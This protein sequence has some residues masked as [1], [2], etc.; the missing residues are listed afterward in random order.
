MSISHNRS[1]FDGKSDN[2]EPVLDNEIKEEFYKI[3]STLLKDNSKYE[4]IYTYEA[5]YDYLKKYDKLNVVYYA[6]I[7]TLIYF[8]TDQNKYVKDLSSNIEKCALSVS[9]IYQACK[10]DEHNWVIARIYRFIIKLGDHISLAESQI[11][12]IVNTVMNDAVAKINELSDKMNDLV[13]TRSTELLNNMDKKVNQRFS[14]NQKRMK[15]FYKGLEK[16]SITILGIFVAIIL[17]FMGSIILPS[18]LIKNVSN[19]SIARLVLVFTG[20]AFIFINMLYLLIKFIVI[21]NDKDKYLNKLSYI[22]G[23]N[24]CLLIIFLISLLGVFF[25]DNIVELQQS[26]LDN[27]SKYL[28]NKTK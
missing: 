28:D 4:P 10:N 1:T 3:L 20:I 16:D 9:A 6:S 2:I 15:K 27:S 17:A 21:I 7:T 22:C 12:K 24:W 13:E 18:E 11:D 14:S 8:N 19:I 25:T 26:V 23:I 5:I